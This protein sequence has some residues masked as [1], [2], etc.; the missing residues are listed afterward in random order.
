MYYFNNKLDALLL[1][2]IIYCW[3]RQHARFAI[4]ETC[5]FQHNQDFFLMYIQNS[6]R[7][8]FHAAWSLTL[9]LSCALN[10]FFIYITPKSD[11]V[12]HIYS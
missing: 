3:T 9:P 10:L 2:F 12:T 5:E 6:K 11:A 7:F 8:F 4:R 1:M